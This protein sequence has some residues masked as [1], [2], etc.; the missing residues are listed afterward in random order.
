[1]RARGPTTNKNQWYRAS[2][3]CG[4]QRRQL[5]TQNTQKW[6]STNYGNRSLFSWRSRT[7]TVEGRV[8][9]W[10]LKLII[11]MI[12]PRSR[13]SSQV[14]GFLL[15]VAGNAL[16]I[17]YGFPPL[18]KQLPTLGPWE[19][20]CSL[21]G[22]SLWVQ[23]LELWSQNYSK[24]MGN[25]ESVRP[26]CDKMGTNAGIFSRNVVCGWSLRWDWKCQLSR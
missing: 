18:F 3:N 14:A 1:M 17:T 9:P 11:S 12:E 19:C 22:R 25:I 7:P 23:A 4:S 24:S 6:S 21:L 16:Q 2:W 10:A 5:N 26:Y 20:W 13:V 15:G 8:H